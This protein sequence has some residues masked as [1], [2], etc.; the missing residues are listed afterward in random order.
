[1]GS[2]FIFIFLYFFSSTFYPYFLSMA[3]SLPNY[4]KKTRDKGGKNM[5]LR[6]LTFDDAFFNRNWAGASWNCWVGP[7]ALDARLLCKN[8]KPKGSA[9]TH[10]LPLR[11][12]SQFFLMEENINYLGNERQRASPRRS[13][14]FLVFAEE[15][16]IQSQRTG[17][18]IPAHSSPVSVEKDII[19]WRRLWE[20][21][22]LYK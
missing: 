10:P 5:V 7:L 13:F 17:P 14:W 22:F 19:S 8:K 12:L 3:F 9:G 2:N 18:V 20:R 11:C 21:Q 16:G 4:E 1:M 15:S 6:S